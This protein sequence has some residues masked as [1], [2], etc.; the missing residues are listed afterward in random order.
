MM[1][2]HLIHTS[3]QRGE[4]EAGEA[5]KPFQRFSN[6]P[7]KRL[8][9]STAHSP[10]SLK[11]GVNEIGSTATGGLRVGNTRLQN[12]LRRIPQATPPI[13]L[14]RQAGRYHRHYQNLRRQFS[15]MDLCKQPEL[16]AQVALGPVLDFD[17]DA[18]ILF[19]DLLFPL[20]ALGM[21]LEYTDAGPQL[22]WKLTGESISQLNDVDEAGPQLLFQGE[23]VRATRKLLPNHRSLIGFVGGPWTLFVYAVE[24]THKHVE[25]AVKELPLFER[26]CET[27]VPLLSRNIAHQL[28]NGAEVV[29]VFD[30]AAGE[31]SS[32]V[33]KSAVVPQL[34][35]LTRAFPSSLGYYSK[36][37]SRAHLDHSL[38][39][40]G[41]FAGIGVDH[42]WDL[43]DAFA[44]FSHGFVQGNFD[45]NL[46]R[47]SSP[48]ALKQQLKTFL[49]PLLKRDRSGWTCG[50]GHGV[51]PKTPEENV[52][53]F[54]NTVREVLQ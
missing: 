36:G 28:E 25:H 8:I 20:E 33:F 47:D 16:A 37:T 38:F 2:E 32:D 17:F 46:L 29:M 44:M 49:G 50:L 30:T 3:L 40:D 24:G 48:D 35:R 10:T 21:G 19:S 51:L 7:L 31:L 22:G 52:R 41:S 6:K 12:A 11:R 34:D 27:M 45:Q 53:L 54:V 15:F 43:R 39:T 42:N 14:M 23:A 13:W 26:F 18:A 4:S 5:G 1:K 9:D